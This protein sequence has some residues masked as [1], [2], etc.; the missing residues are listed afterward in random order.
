MCPTRSAADI[1][2]IQVFADVDANHD[3][4]ISEGELAAAMR[5]LIGGNAGGRGAAAPPPPP[6]AR[7][8]FVDP[9]TTAAFLN[10]R[11]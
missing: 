5:A 9:A 11:S 4:V 10:R 6:D 2:L 1:T 8:K 7:R 3:R